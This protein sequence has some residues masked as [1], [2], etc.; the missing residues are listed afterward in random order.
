MTPRLCT[1]SGNLEHSFSEDSVIP[2]SMNYLSDNNVIH[3][4]DQNTFFNTF[5]FKRQG[6]KNIKLEIRMKNHIG[7]YNWYRLQG[8]V[9]Y[10][11][12]GTP[13]QIIGKTIDIDASKQQF[14]KLQEEANRDNLT[15]LFNTSALAEKSDALLR[16]KAPEEEAAL[17]LLDLDHF[18]ILV[19]HYGRLVADTVLSQTAVILNDVFPAQ[20]VGRIDNDQFVVFLPSIQSKEDIEKKA[21]EVCNLIHAIE[22]KDTPD[23]SVSCSIG[24][25]STKETKDF[26]FEIMLLRANVALRTI[27][28]KGGNGVEIYGNLPKRYSVTSDAKDA[29]RN[30]Y[31][32]LTGLYSLPAFII[33]SEQILSRQ[34]ADQKTAIVYFDINSFTIFNANYGFTV[35]NKIL[36]YFARVLEES[37]QPN[38]LCCHI[39]NDEFVCMLFYNQTQDLSDRFSAL[40]DRLN[41]KDTKIEDYFRFN[42]TC[43]V[44]LSGN[45][46]MDIATMIDKANYARKSTKGVTET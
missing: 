42:F 27:K 36:K 24:Y 43:G 15:Q 20:L 32:T 19:D 46:T 25:F 7:L 33:E 38:E 41:A 9:M 29:K 28:S 22:V 34:P 45:E 10:D 18:K 14:L 16:K 13:Y 35:G 31:D 6:K 26:T 39:Q 30:Y 21:Q 23:F 44:C 11:D 4:D 17:L 2:D 37:M 5:Q 8:I 3:I 12:T 40:K 1:V